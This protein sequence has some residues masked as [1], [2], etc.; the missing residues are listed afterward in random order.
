MPNVDA[1]NGL[2]SKISGEYLLSEFNL[3]PP[4]YVIQKQ[5]RSLTKE[6]T[7]H[8]LPTLDKNEWNRIFFNN[9]NLINFYSNI[10][11]Q[12]TDKSIFV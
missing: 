1:V 6:F 8:S 7:I 12:K 4:I 3:I 5:E 11:K 2:I 10:Q 9:D